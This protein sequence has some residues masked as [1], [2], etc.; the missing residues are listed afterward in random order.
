M[1]DA[2][3][4]LQPDLQ[5][6]QVL[7]AATTGVGVIGVVAT[8]VPFVESMQP[9]EAAKAAGAPVEF[10]L[11]GL[12]PGK[13]ATVEWRGKPVWVLHRTDAMLASLKKDDALLADPDSKKP[14]QPSYAENDARAI[15]PPFLV[16]IGICTH[17]GCVPTY[18]PEAGAPDLGA[19]WPGGF[20][21]PCH[22][23][24][25]DLSGRVF[26]NVPA[27]LNLEVPPYT[28]LSDTKLLIGSDS[29]KQA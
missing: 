6:R 23:S 26:K 7:R 9:S 12:A 27:P 21:C 19:N 22:G 5:R 24:K 14:Q 28:Y 4:E 3:T 20:Y 8:A 11:G 13:I 29:K 15:R 10:D 2:Q 18:R 25:Y 16:V 17:L 1:S